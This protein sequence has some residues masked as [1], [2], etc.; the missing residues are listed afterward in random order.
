MVRST[1]SCRAAIALL[2][3]IACASPSGYDSVTGTVTYR[4]R[5][6]LPSD[7]QVHVMLLDVSRADAPA[8][9][10]AESTF[11][12][13][14]RQVPFRFT[15]GYRPSEIDN[16]HS[17]VVRSEI[18]ADGAL[19][20]TTDQAHPVITGGAALSADLV[21]VR[22]AAAAMQPNTARVRTGHLV[23]AA[24]AMH[25]IPCGESGPGMLLDDATEGDAAAIVRQLGGEG[26]EVT[27]LV[28]LDDTRLMAV[29][30]AALEGPSCETLLDG[31]DIV[32]RGNEPFWHAAVSDG[33]LIVR[34]PED[35]ARY[36]GRGW[37]APGPGLWRYEAGRGVGGT[38]EQVVLELREERCIDSM[39][40]AYHP[41]TAM[42]ARN[43]TAM[44][45]CA[46][47]GRPGD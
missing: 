22:V 25:F 41:F 42:L 3:S 46:V 13:D 37:V 28:V 38:V 35:S 34:T 16:T 1:V 30:Y 29:R 11:T 21:L 24:E 23:L 44:T 14:G 18:T 9:T 6:A 12:T 40:G 8:I 10:I 17:Y 2:A 31:S 27:A 43:G 32:A 7:A 45:G 20:F 15:L 36:P 19:M 39:S 4:E 5:I 47:E 33:V 26:H